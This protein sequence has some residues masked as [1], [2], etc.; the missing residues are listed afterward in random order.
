MP[1]IRGVI[2]RRMLVNFR[3]PPEVLARIVPAPFRPKIIRGWGMAGIC[4]IRLGA[5]RPPLVPACLGIRSE[6]AAHRIAVEWDDAG[7]LREGVF[8]PR[9]DTNSWLNQMAGGRIFPGA[10]HAASF[11]V[12]ESGENFKLEMRS[13]DGDTSLRIHARV[14]GKSPSQSVFRSLAEASAFFRGGALGWSTRPVDKSLDGLELDCPEW[15]LEPLAVDHLESSYFQNPDLFPPGSAEFDSAF[16]MRNVPHEW[17]A[18]GTLTTN[19][20]EAT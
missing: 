5:I 19:A 12:W 1:V 14:T 18:R 10:H 17:H 11:Q 16:L 6:N 13:A 9:R 4:L 3:C 8:I 2:E 7:K 20:T 15:R